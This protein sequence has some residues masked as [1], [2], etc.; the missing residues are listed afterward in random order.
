MTVVSPTNTTFNK[1][2]S[3]LSAHVNR[4]EQPPRSRPRRFWHE[5][6][7]SVAPQR[8]SQ[9]GGSRSVVAIKDVFLLSTNSEFFSRHQRRN[10]RQR[11]QR[12]TQNRDV[13]RGVGYSSCPTLRLELFVVSRH[14]DNDGS[15][16]H[17]TEL[18]KSR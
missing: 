16:R 11:R 1:F 17:R 18:Y 12:P 15:G 4:T 2:V 9:L 8:T 3:G 6:R 10:K 5:I 7:S 14:F 13:Q